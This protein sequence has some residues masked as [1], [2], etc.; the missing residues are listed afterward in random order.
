MGKASRR[1][2]ELRASSI[3]PD[4][5]SVEEMSRRAVA[6]ILGLLACFML[7]VALISVPIPE[8]SELVYL[9]PEAVELERGRFSKSGG[10]Y[11]I[12]RTPS[13]PTELE[14]RGEHRFELERTLQEGQ[15]VELWVQPGGGLEGRARVW[16]AR[17]GDRVVVPYTDSV[18]AAHDYTLTLLKICGSSA[19]VSIGL[20]G[21][22]WVAT[23]VRQ[24]VA[25]WQRTQ[26][27]G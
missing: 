8:P 21:Y 23:R 10:W 18:R 27:A 1:K 15:P 13:H 22:G 17:A 16:Q 4:Y 14:Y 5:L 9:H 24:L 11:V 2:R 26:P 12:I 6:I 3:P 7:V 19:L 20:W 25:H